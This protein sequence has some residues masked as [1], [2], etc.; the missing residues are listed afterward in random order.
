V[1]MRVR[2]CVWGE[3]RYFIHEM[4]LVS[5]L[6]RCW[7]CENSSV[8]SMHNPSYCYGIIEVLQVSALSGDLFLHS[9]VFFLTE[10]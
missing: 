6:Y 4:V 9:F 3:V 2:V 7:F 8:K 5:S 1:R 10:L